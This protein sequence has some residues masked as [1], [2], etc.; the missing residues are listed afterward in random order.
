MIRSRTFD[1]GV[2]YAIYILLKGAVSLRDRGCE[3]R[4]QHRHP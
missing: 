3:W 4:A 1:G 2:D